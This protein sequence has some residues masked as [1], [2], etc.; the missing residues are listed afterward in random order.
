[1]LEQ[2]VTALLELQNP[3]GGWGAHRSGTSQTETTSLAIMALETSNGGSLTDSIRFGKA[4]LHARQRPEGAWPR[5]DDVPEPSWMTGLA[6][7]ALRRDPEDRPKV[8]DGASWLLGL[9]GRATPLLGRVLARLIGAPPIVETGPI[10]SGLALEAGHLWMGRTDLIRFA[11]P[12]D[13]S[14]RASSPPHRGQDP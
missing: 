14:L 7:M 10:L 1:M 6:M 13:V 12:E 9:R 5:S 3:D 4:W 8:L 11:G 2:P